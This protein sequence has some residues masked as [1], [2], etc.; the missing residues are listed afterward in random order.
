MLVLAVL[1]GLPALIVAAGAVIGVRIVL[2]LP[3]V[4]DF[5]ETFP[6][7]YEL[8]PGTEP[9]FPAFVR[10][11]HFFS[12]FLMLLIIR[13]GWQIRTEKRPRA[14]WKPRWAKG[15]R[16]KVSLTI[17]FHQTL[18]VL[19]I[20]NGV[21][22]VVLLF[23]SGHWVR[24]VPTS[25][26]VIPNAISAAL[27]YVSLD[28]PT[29]DGWVNYNSLQQLMYFITVF[30]AAPLAIVTGIRMSAIWPKDTHR[31][32]KRYPIEWARAVHFPVML[33]FLMFI[34]VHVTL[35][36]A[37]GALRNLNHISVGTHEESW[38]GVILLAGAVVV[39]TAA[40]LLARPLVLAPIA[41][42]SGAVSER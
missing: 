33:Y 20:A 9:G 41:R 11:Q 34:V 18:D 19:W 36:L 25:W 21:V 13:S 6:G 30:V 4:A 26:E 29:H 5:V 38:V 35:V 14:F 39:M 42:L 2:D 16:G 37:T 24:I 27:Q 17:W 22:F 12:A 10:W 28:W 3:A 31:L 7:E 15:G 40:L 23:V 1:L 8:P 32:N